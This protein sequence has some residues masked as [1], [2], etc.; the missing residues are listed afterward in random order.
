MNKNI[1]D[2]L[3]TNC[4]HGWFSGEAGLQVAQNFLHTLT[5]R[6]QH[7]INVPYL[8]L[9]ITCYKEFTN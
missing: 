5:Q 9:F 1:T 6:A 2:L 3:H 8:I 4:S 7:F